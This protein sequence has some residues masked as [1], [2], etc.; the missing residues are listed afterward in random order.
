MIRTYETRKAIEEKFNKA[1]PTDSSVEFIYKGFILH[2]RRD[3]QFG[4]TYYDVY[5]CFNPMFAQ[6]QCSGPTMKANNKK[7]AMRE[8]DNLIEL[9]SGGRSDYSLIGDFD[10]K[11]ATA[12]YIHKVQQ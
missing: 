3:S 2:R 6:S 7:D 9:A 11:I 4:F 12:W 1:L 8:V 10:E 5:N